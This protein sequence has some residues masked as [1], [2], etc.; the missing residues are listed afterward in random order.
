MSYLLVWIQMGTPVS[1]SR[2]VAE[3]AKE[4]DTALDAGYTVAFTAT[5]DRQ[6]LVYLH[7][8]TAAEKAKQAVLDSL[9]NRFNT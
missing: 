8:N 1:G 3:A 5:S 6:T 9:A 7:K 4:I 2:E